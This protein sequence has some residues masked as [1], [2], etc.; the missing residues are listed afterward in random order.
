[1]PMLVAEQELYRSCRV[2]FGSDL[3][4]GRDFL[5]YLRHSGLKKA[6]RLKARQTHPDLAPAN[7]AKSATAILADFISVQQAYE[8]LRRYLEYRDRGFRFQAGG[9]SGAP[10]FADRS[11][12]G[13][14]AGHGRPRPGH[15]S[16]RP[17]AKAGGRQGASATDPYTRLYSGPIPPVRMRFG[18]FLYYSGMIDLMTIVKALIWQRS[19]R[20]RLGELARRF[21]WLSDAQVSEVLAGCCVSREKFGAS[22]IRRRLLT[23]RQLTILLGQQKFLQKKF[24][25]FLL[26]Q[27]IFT[28]EQIEEMLRRHA[29]HNAAY[30]GPWVA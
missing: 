2:L 22:A 8:N 24:G 15:W 18:N 7:S 3:A 6:Y 30:G 12:R 16:E 11:G 25:A 14:A 29:G 1:M 26:E 21:G 5:G 23:E 27:R 4:V 20:P 10:P 17:A 9:R 28:S 19:Q 13:P